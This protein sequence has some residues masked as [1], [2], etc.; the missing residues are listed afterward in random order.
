MDKHLA[1]KLGIV[2]NTDSWPFFEQY[3]QQEL[4]RAYVKFD[5]VRELQEFSAVQAEIKILKKFLN[6]K[7]LIRQSVEN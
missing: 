7:E 1:K 6:L 4:D 5:N 3:T 2:I